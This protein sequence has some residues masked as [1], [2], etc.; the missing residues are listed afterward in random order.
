MTPSFLP[1]EGGLGFRLDRLVRALRAGWAAELAGIG[2]TPPQAA[3]LRGVAGADGVSVRALARRLGG[4]PMNVKRC[5]DELEQRSLLRSGT[6]AGDRRPRV[7]TA[8]DEGRALAGEVDRRVRGQ[9]A[10]LT[11]ALGRTARP[12]FERALGALEADLGLALTPGAD[13]PSGGGRPTPS[14]RNRSTDRAKEPLP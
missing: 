6:D 11:D 14:R 7:L 9:D 3:V 5:A 1:L 2:L 12:A 8:T 10:R 4:D 13:G